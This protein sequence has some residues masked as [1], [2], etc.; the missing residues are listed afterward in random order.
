[1]ILQKDPESERDK[2]E[3]EAEAE[4]R[5]EW[6][7][8]DKNK[9][10]RQTQRGSSNMRRR[11]EECAVRRKRDVNAKDKRG[12]KEVALGKTFAYPS[13]PRFSSLISRECSEQ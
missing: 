4:K 3:R 2:A 5:R 7:Q 8:Q 10:R 12:D 9:K 11:E 13:F 1:M 6:L